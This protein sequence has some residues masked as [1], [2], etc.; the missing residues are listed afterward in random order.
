[1]DMQKIFSYCWRGLAVGLILGFAGCRS[2]GVSMV[3]KDRQPTDA[4]ALTDALASKDGMYTYY[5]T[6]SNYDMRTSLPV[7]GVNLVFNSPEDFYAERFQTFPE[8]Y[9]K[10]I[11]GINTSANQDVWKYY[12]SGSYDGSTHDG[13]ILRRADGSQWSFGLLEGV[14]YI[15]PT[16]SWNGYLRVIGE[17][18]IQAGA[19]FFTVQEM[20]IWGDSGC[21]EAFRREW[22]EYYG[23]EWEAPFYDQNL[24]YRSQ[25][26]RNYLITRQIRQVFEPLKRQYPQVKFQI[27]SHTSLAYYSFKNPVGN[28]DLLALDCVDALEGQTWSNTLEIPFAYD[29]K[30]MARPF[31]NGYVDYSYWANLARQFPDKAVSF[32]TDPKGDGYDGKT[33]EECWEL[34]R[35]QVTAQL[36]FSNIYR[37]NSCVWPNRAYSEGYDNL[38]HTTPAYKTVMN[39][40][41]SLQGQMYRYQEAVRT[42][43]RPVKIGAV[44]LDTACY[45]AGGPGSSVGLNSYYGMLA[46]LMYN[47][48]MVDAIP[49]GSVESPVPKLEEYDLILLGYDLMKPPNPLFHEQIKTYIQNGGTV[50]Y[51]GGSGEYEDIQDSW[52]KKAGFASPQDHLLS[53]LGCQAEGRVKN[54]RTQCL[55]A[56]PAAPIAQAVGDIT[57]KIDKASLIGYRDVRS[58][59]VLYTAEKTVLAFE[60]T[61][62]SGA[63][64]YFGI[65][66]AYFAMSGTGDTLF[67]L[68]RAVVSQQLSKDMIRQTALSYKRGPIYGYN[69]LAGGDTHAGLYL[70]MFD[71][72][73]PV[74]EKLTLEAGDSA[75]LLD[76]SEKYASG[77]PTVLFAQGNNPTIVENWD[78]TRVVTAGPDE[79]E[80]CVRLYIPEGYRISGLTAT[81]MV[82]QKSALV[83]RV[84][85]AP[86]R[87]LLI[88]YKNNV[89][90]VIIDVRYVL[91]ESA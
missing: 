21:E 34:Y 52:W 76:V 10:K 26:L 81:N 87:S 16:E 25:E 11:M 59:R 27:A 23:E 39:N 70:D 42:D 83:D 8:N 75:L 1:M 84:Y 48:I 37:Y 53:A 28:F 77:K 17:K 40:I 86:S 33:L 88:T 3:E 62:G 58:A 19:S 24:Y 82:T 85:D 9:D 13:E 79:S 15:L 78:I 45:Q 80:G 50:M 72:K 6:D 35:H 44:L 61:L 74:V 38:P 69:A 41:I 71:E 22:R 36:A 65:D 89:S 54:V 4:G 67:E 91:E 56:Q 63:F 46:G 32:I 30:T 90:K 2:G 18:G 7:D 64:Y 73:L 49:A 31:I 43:N 12:T 51:M 20:G 60:H 5:S 55:V 68:V 57:Q 66:P 47:G 29:G 14:P